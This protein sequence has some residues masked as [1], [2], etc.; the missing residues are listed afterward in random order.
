MAFFS[1]PCAYCTLSLIVWNM[2]PFISNIRHG[3]SV[4]V[5]ILKVFYRVCDEVSHDIS[6]VISFLVKYISL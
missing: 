6:S 2:D 5:L 4:V 3:I 1:V